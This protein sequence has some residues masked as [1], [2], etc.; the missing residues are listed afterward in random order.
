M[1]DLFA[2]DTY[3]CVALSPADAL[4]SLCSLIHRLD[5]HQDSLLHNYRPRLHT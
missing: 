5:S 1:P 2:E 4:I 3:A